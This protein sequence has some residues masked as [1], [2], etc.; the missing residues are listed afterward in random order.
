MAG[1]LR[2]RGFADVV[3]IGQRETLTANRTD[4]LRHAALSMVAHARRR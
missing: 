3:S 1:L 4:A 2:E